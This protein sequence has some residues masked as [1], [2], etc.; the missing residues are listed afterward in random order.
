MIEQTK[1]TELRRRL[2]LEQEEVREP[3]EMPGQE[4]LADD[5]DNADQGD[6][7]LQYSALESASIVRARLEDRLNAIDAALARLDQGVYGR[8]QRC[9]KEIPIERLELEP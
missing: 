3:M 8:C 4:K 5:L 7:A 9:G 2:E 6:L 1:Q